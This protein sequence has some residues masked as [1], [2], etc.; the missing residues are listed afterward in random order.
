MKDVLVSLSRRQF[1]GAIAG[2]VALASCG[3]S[4]GGS[5]DAM[6]MTDGETSGVC[7]TTGA[8]DVGAA[9]TFVAGTPVY[10]SDDRHPVRRVL[11]P[12]SRLAVHVRR[13]RGARTRDAGAEPLRD[14]PDR[15][16][17]RRRADVG[18]GGGDRSPERLITSAAMAE[19]LTYSLED[20]IAVVRMDDG[21][22]NALSVTMIDALLAALDRAEGE[23]K[24]LVLAGRDE[25]FCAGFDLRVMMS[26]PEQATALLTRGS[27]L[28]MR[29]YEAK[30]PLVIACTGHALA[31]G[32]LVVLTGDLRIG[33][34]GAF[35]LGLNEV[36]IGLPVPVLAM[37][38]ARDRLAKAE[39]V[40]ATLMAQ[41][42]APDEAVRAGY[43]DEVVP[44][45]ELLARAKA[46]AA[47]LGALPSQA[48][49]ATK[50]RLR[51]ATIDHIRS[52]LATDMATIMKPA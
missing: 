41:I 27:E 13:Q 51:K 10:F 6:P 20:S 40:R 1:C 32:A 26:G 29:L 31:G 14:V 37:E 38:L 48:F 46:E 9:G 44:A 25:R 30:V 8:V 21:K 47:R 2:C 18:G 16:R 33:A 34:Q 23:A 12:A 17:Q 52:S 35:K 7:P 49:R 24:A 22:A 42:Y 43:L 3:G 15:E 39:L 11:L 36:S 28:L 50:T 4:D 45:V 5:P 19:P